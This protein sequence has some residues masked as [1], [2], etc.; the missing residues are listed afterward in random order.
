MAPGGAREA[1]LVIFPPATKF[2]PLARARP[3]AGPSRTG[4]LTRQ[5]L[6]GCLLGAAGS[7]NALKERIFHAP[8]PNYGRVMANR[9]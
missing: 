5:G 9:A 6:S 4:W 8:A 1:V 7:R 3:S 2:P